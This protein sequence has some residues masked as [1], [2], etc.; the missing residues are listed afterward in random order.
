[1]S[2][3]NWIHENFKLILTKA[4]LLD[5]ASGSFV[6][7]IRMK[8]AGRLF[9]TDFY[10]IRHTEELALG[11]PLSLTEQQYQEMLEDRNAL[12]NISTEVLDT[13]DPAFV[14]PVC[15]EWM[16]LPPM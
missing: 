13:S 5:D 7:T 12:R 9:D 1:M 4:P 11:L 10:G 2:E 8:R 16:N 14:W 3:I 6:V 15:P